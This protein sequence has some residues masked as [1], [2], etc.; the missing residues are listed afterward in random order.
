MQ[1]ALGRFRAAMGR[2]GRVAGSAP[3]PNGASKQE[4][5][6][7]LREWEAGRD[8]LNSFSDALNAATGTSR[9]QTIPA[10]YLSYA[11]SKERYTQLVKDT[12]LC[13]NRGGEQLA[14]LWG[15]LMVYGTVPGVNPC[16][17]INLANYFQ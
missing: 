15:N 14:G 3:G 12:A 9:M 5:A 7:A 10:D 16:G 1:A 13:R 2:L 6:T 11:R 8:A 4:L 17:D